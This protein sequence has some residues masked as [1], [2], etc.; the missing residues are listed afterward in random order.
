MK[1]EFSKAFHPQVAAWKS[2]RLGLAVMTL[3]V[4]GLTHAASLT[5]TDPYLL[6]GNV[7]ANSV[8]EAAGVRLLGG[9]ESGRP[10]AT[11]GTTATANTGVSTIT[12]NNIPFTTAPNFWSATTSYSANKAG[13]WTLSFSNGADTKQTTTPSAASAS[14]VPF[15]QNMTVTGTGA[16]P[17]FNWSVPTTAAFDA[18]RIQIWDTGRTVS[19]SGLSDI[20]F[21]QGLSPQTRSFEVPA[22]V[23][24]KPL[25]FG[26]QY[27]IE[28][29]LIDTRNNSFNDVS[30]SNTLSR[31]KSFFDFTLSNNP[32][33]PANVVLPSVE[34]G[35]PG[36]APTYRFDVTNVGGRTVFIDPDVA[37]GYDY[38]TGNGDPNFSS[39]LLPTGIG[40]NRFTLTLPDGTQVNIN[41]GE[42][43]SFLNRNPNGIDSFKV[44]GIE[45]SAMLDPFN[46][47]AFVTGL[48]F[49]A[50]S[51]AGNFTGTMIPIIQ[52][53]DGNV[54]IGGTIG[55]LAAGLFVT[56]GV[57]RGR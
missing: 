20:I 14:V 32:N 16:S 29:A 22:A 38:K 4:P 49:S 37:V 10:S 15:V 50:A 7:S 2:K 46:V 31:S 28:I 13:P 56:A 42:K 26:R 51:G 25:E 24:G 18:Q 8:G 39:V 52:S 34:L 47:T 44:T 5:L 17:V 57:R 30:V 23:N 33:Q 19:A 1:F 55:L 21:A 36:Q 12:L 54:P 6:L 53:I 48:E 45:T 40:D 41:G 27:A 35:G 11:A 43:F 9:V 3:C